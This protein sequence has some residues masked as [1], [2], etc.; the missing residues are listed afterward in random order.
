[1]SDSNVKK[2][3]IAM[4][5]GV[6]SSVTALLIKE[7]GCDCMGAT[8]NLFQ[9]E[10]VGIPMSKSCCSLNDI[11][12]A[13]AVCK[14]IGIEHRVFNLQEKFKEKVIDRFVYAYENGMTP[15]PCIDCN[16]HLKFGRL[17][18]RANACG[19]SHISTG[20]YARI[21]QDENTGRWLLKKAKDLSKDQTYVL[22]SL[23]QDVLSRLLLPLGNYTKSE[24]RKIA[25]AHNF[26]NA[27]KAESQDICFV[28]DQE[29]PDFI[30]MYT[31][32]SYP[33]GNFIDL[34]GN[35]L[36]KHKGIIRYTIGQRK[37][38]GIAFGVPMYV[39]DKDPVQ[40]TVTLARNDELFSREVTATDINLISTEQLKD[41]TPVFAKTR[42]NQKEQP[43]IAVQTA[44][45][46][47]RVIF[48]EPQRAITK[49]QALV[50]YH[51]NS[52]VGGGT[53]I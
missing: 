5:G 41:E 27:A 23:S 50:M 48:N 15:N 21:E 45:D 51:G 29:Y 39:Y 44:P 11:N 36:G 8:M 14:N 40:N 33:P 25:S 20:H 10:D 26:V 37:G 4:S 32:R 52:V 13:A 43:A 46:T 38:L 17:T 16:R 31:G 35:V 47:L 2:V 28:K 6:D 53:I 49:G 3:L 7:S 22:Y 34:H 12:D 1:M 9:N 18:E 42:Y 19:C 24:V 30:E